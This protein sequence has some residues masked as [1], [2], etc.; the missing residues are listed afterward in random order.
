M[1]TPRNPNIIYVDLDVDRTSLQVTYHADE[2]RFVLVFS[3]PFQHEGKRVDGL[4]LFLPANV[5]RQM[6]QALADEQ[7]H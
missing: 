1:S 7:A 2:E 5:V 3:R 4:Q 6:A